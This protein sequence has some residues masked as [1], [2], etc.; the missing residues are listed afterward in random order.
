[1]HLLKCCVVFSDTIPG[2]QCMASFLFLRN[3]FDNA[4]V[5]LTSV[6]V[7][8]NILYVLISVA[9]PHYATGIFLQ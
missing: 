7:Q 9:L 5:Y 4:L 3:E 1:M 6:K 8:Y 2:R